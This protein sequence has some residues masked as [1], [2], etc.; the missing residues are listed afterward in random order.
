MTKEMQPHELGAFGAYAA[1]AI[2]NK[3]ADDRDYWKARAERAES[4]RDALRA[5]LDAAQV[6]AERRAD[7]LKTELDWLRDQVERVGYQ[8]PNSPPPVGKWYWD[9][10]YNGG[11]VR[12]E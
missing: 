12:Q 2:A 1:E 9:Q 10:E 4:E 8:N 5:E 11:W 3:I 7:D 6:A